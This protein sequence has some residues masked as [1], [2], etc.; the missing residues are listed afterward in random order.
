M[1]FLLSDYDLNF[2]VWKIR[3]GICR[4]WYGFSNQVCLG[5][6]YRPRFQ[7]DKPGF[8]DE[9]HFLLEKLGFSGEKPSLSA[10]KPGFSDEPRFQSE[11]PGLS[12]A[13]VLSGEK[14]SLSG[15]KPSLSEKNLVYL[16]V[17]T[18]AFLNL[19]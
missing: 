18:F 7:F 5:F 8:S 17:V 10:E 3:N 2:I 16:I 13:F 15:E 11:K 12:D 9:P 4:K 19:R 14:P 6:V 1:K